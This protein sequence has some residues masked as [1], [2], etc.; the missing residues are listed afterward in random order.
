MPY[1]YIPISNIRYWIYNILEQISTPSRTE[2]FSVRNDHLFTKVTVVSL[3]RGVGSLCWT[4]VSIVC[5]C[6][7]ALGA[8]LEFLFVLSFASL[9]L[10][11]FYGLDRDATQRKNGYAKIDKIQ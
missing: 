8:L 1:G 7:R 3:Q 9:P 5:V 2:R 6:V 4:F 11:C 10:S